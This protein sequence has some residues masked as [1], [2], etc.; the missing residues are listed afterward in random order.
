ME[1]GPTRNAAYAADEPYP[2]VEDER[3][4]LLERLAGL[5]SVVSTVALH[6]LPGVMAWALSAG[7]GLNVLAPIVAEAAVQERLGRLATLLSVVAAILATETVVWRA[8]PFGLVPLLATGGVLM[9]ALFPFL[10]APHQ[11]TFGV[12]PALVGIL[13][14]YGYLVLQATVGVIIGATVSWLFLAFGAASPPPRPTPRK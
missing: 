3:S 2:E 13:L 9:A 12:A 8:R 5:M 1:L 11:L 4:E 14:S 6:A 7:K 10:A